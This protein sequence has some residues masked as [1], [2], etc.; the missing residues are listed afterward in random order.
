M[1][2]KQISADSQVAPNLVPMVD[3]MFLLLLFFM[4]GADMGQ[5][6]LEEVML[7][8]ADSVKEDKQDI[9]A[10]KLENQRLTINVFHETPDDEKR[11]KGECQDY[12]KSR[13]SGTVC[14]VDGHWAV[15][16][17]GEEF[18]EPEK[19]K[20]RLQ[21]IVL[22]DREK[23]GETKLVVEAGKPRPASE[24]RVMIRADGAALYSRVQMAMNACGASGT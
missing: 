4:L 9:D 24:L 16:I 15:G 22:I 6:E 2:V 8:I 20:G 19:L 3:I 11:E 17:H 1:A 5:R 14:H 10:S 7:P 12:A 13:E 23:R 21:E 18:K